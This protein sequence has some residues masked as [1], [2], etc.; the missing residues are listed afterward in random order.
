[1]AEKEKDNIKL[2]VN[3]E[4]KQL[5]KN[6]MQHVE[7]HM[8]WLNANSPKK[9]LFAQLRNA[10]KTEEMREDSLSW[11]LKNFI[12]IALMNRYDKKGGETHSGKACLTLL[13][14]PEYAELKKIL[15]ANAKDKLLYEDLFLLVNGNMSL[16]NKL[17]SSS[18]CQ[19]SLYR[20][21]GIT[22]DNKKIAPEK[23]DVAKKRFVYEP[24]L[25]A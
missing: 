21:F 3:E 17:L 1:M 19:G 20:S 10:L 12:G 16:C 13:N 2:P 11:L 15:F 14:K 9:T 23:L 8:G 25:K 22:K 24:S 6:Y 5:A 18:R 4:L 7:T